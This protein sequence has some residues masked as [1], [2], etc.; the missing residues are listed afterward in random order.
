MFTPRSVRLSNSIS[1]ERFRIFSQL[2]CVVLT[3]CSTRET[4][5]ARCPNPA[6]S[7]AEQRPSTLDGVASLDCWCCCSCHTNTTDISFTLLLRSVTPGLHYVYVSDTRGRIMIT[8]YQCYLCS[9]SVCTCVRLC[10]TYDIPDTQPPYSYLVLLIIVR[11]G[12]WTNAT[13]YTY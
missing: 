2:K 6:S 1:R 5:P 13:S 4:S 9:S 8:W 3:V 11:A 7:R 10:T 12:V